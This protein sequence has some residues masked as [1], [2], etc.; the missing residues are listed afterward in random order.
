VFQDLVLVVHG[1]H[2]ACVNHDIAYLACHCLS[3]VSYPCGVTRTTLRGVSSCVSITSSSVDCRPLVPLK[4]RFST[5]DEIT[6]SSTP[7]C[8]RGIRYCGNWSKKVGA[9][10]GIKPTP[11]LIAKM[12]VLCLLFLKSTVCKTR[13]PEAATMPNITMAAPPSTYCGTRATTWAI[14]GTSPKIIRI[15]PPARQT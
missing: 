9:I 15:R 10:A 5:T 7:L 3:P 8:N 6:V 2:F 1:D 4:N 12:K 14:R 13:T 11:R